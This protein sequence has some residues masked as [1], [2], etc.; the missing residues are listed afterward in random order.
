MALTYTDTS[1]TNGQIRY[2]AIAAVNVGGEG[3]LST[4]VNATPEA[5]P[6]TAPTG[7]A[8]APGNGQVVL[9]WNTQAQ[10]DSYTL[11]WN[12]TG[13]PNPASDPS[14]TGIMAGRPLPFLKAWTRATSI[15]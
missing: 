10:A 5:P 15:S 6:G 2:Y 4:P 14:I 12:E 1:V 7:L 11:Y 3:P 9:T 8:A 13:Q